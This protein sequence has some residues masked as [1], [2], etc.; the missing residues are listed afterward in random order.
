MNEIDFSLE[1]IHP[2]VFSEL[3]DFFSKINFFREVI[4]NKLMLLISC[5][6][7]CVGRDLNIRNV[8][9]LFSFGVL[10]SCGCWLLL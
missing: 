1:L 7:F 8:V 3:F 10:V 4:K 9:P 5:F 6:S 2:I